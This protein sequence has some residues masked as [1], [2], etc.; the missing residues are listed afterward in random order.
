MKNRFF[1]FLL[2]LTIALVLCSCA[3]GKKT[4]FKYEHDPLENPKAMEDIIVDPYA[5]YGFSPNPESDRL[6]SYAA[7][8]WTDPV[9]VESAQKTRREY[10]ESLKTMVAIMSRMASDGASEEEIARAVSTERNRLRLESAKDDPEVLAEIKASNLKKYGHEEGMTP[11]EAYAKYGSWE[12]VAQKAFSPNL[13][14]DV[15]CGL[16]DENYT[17]YKML[18]YVE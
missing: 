3:T 10:H 1:S 9:F 5:V 16:Y 14:M 4:D 15:I 11:D 17:L 8:D 2:I 18:G 7:Y 6:G 12:V 13:G